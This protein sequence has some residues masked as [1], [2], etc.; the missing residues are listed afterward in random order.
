MAERCFLALDGDDIGSRLEV[1]MINEDVSGLED[2]A[3]A[4][5][6]AL[7]RFSEE[8]AKISSVDVLL[9][10]G[11]SILLTLP[12]GEIP[13]VNQLLHDQMAKVGV[14]FSGG[15]GKGLRQAYL[16]LKLAKATG[17]NRLVRLGVEGSQ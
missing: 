14:T 7:E 3:F 1:C 12:E 9:L 15:Y 13:R 2:F 10:G 16:G 4:F 11:D 6:H 17:K 8:I 5:N